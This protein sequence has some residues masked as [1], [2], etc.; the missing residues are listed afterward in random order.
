MEKTG[1]WI[2]ILDTI[3]QE[4]SVYY[5]NFFYTEFAS[6]KANTPFEKRINFLY[7]QFIPEA[8]YKLVISVKN[9]INPVEV[10]GIIEGTMLVRNVAN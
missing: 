1:I 4:E 9:W 8:D 7:P 6:Y 2:E 10:Y 3:T 5:F